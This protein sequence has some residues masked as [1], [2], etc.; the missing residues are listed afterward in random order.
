MVAFVLADTSSLIF[1]VISYRSGL[2]TT[3]ASFLICQPA[4]ESLVQY[5]VDHP[6]AVWF[7]GPLFAALS[8]LVFKEGLCYGKLEAGML[9]F[10][11]PSVLLGHLADVFIQDDIGDKSVFTFNALSE[12]EKAVLIQKLEQQKF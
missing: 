7:V 1:K 4:E 5:V 3:A 8:G 2:V 10:I 6:V 11:I 12:D 9:T